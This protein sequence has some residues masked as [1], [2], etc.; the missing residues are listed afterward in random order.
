MIEEAYISFETAKLLK[1]K[2]FNE[3]CLYYYFSNGKIG[4]R[5]GLKDRNC[6][7]VNTFSMPTLQMAMRWMREEKGIAVIPILS[8]V[9]DNEKFLWDIEIIVA[10]RMKPIVK[11]GYMSLMNELVK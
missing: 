3:P 4:K 11:D 5:K 2:G 8:S 6:P 7:A 9:L 1:E 10:K